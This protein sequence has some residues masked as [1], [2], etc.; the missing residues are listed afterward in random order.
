MGLAV[1][2]A[3]GALALRPRSDRI[4]FDNFSRI[5]EGMSRAEVEAILGGPPGDYRTVQTVY[6]S[7]HS[8]VDVDTIAGYASGHLPLET[9]GAKVRARW[10][11]NDGYIIID[12]ESGVVAEPTP[13]P[14]YLLSTTGAGEPDPLPSTHFVDTVRWDQY[15][16]DHLLWRAKRQWRRWF[17]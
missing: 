8:W 10:V 7:D 5:Q 15:P 9:I 11:G 12:F 3:A 2:L 6:E 14:V 1:L 16:L 13:F 4:T 17:S